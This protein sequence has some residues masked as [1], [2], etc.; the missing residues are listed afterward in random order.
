VTDRTDRNERC[1]VLG[2]CILVVPSPNGRTMNSQYRRR[3]SACAF[4]FLLAVCVAGCSPT[5]DA[6]GSLSQP[7]ATIPP[8]PTSQPPTSTPTAASG[9]AACL[10]CHGSFAK[11]VSA[12]P[13]FQT[14]GFDVVTPHRFIPHESKEVPECSSCHAAHPLPPVASEI[15]AL[16][17]PNVNWCYSFCH[18]QYSFTS[19]KPCH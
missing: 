11:L 18:H 8:S 7:I 1:R 9:K 14:D 12:P 16:P 10:A 19:C 4:V 5:A 3:L 2:P 15:A 6:T 13:A 17:K